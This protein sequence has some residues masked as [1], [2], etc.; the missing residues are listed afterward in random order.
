MLALLDDVIDN[1]VFITR[2]ARESTIFLAPPPEHREVSLLLGPLAAALLNV[3]H[4]VAQ[5][6]RGRHLNQHVNVVS[7]TVDAIQNAFSAIDYSSYVA[8]KVFACFIRDGH[9]AIVRTDDNMINC[10]Y[11]THRVV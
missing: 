4:Q 10:F 3:A 6:Y 2:A 5:R 7:N 9:L 1:H 8:I 11:K